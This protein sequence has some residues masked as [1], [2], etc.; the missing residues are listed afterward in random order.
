M[1]KKPQKII[2]VACL[3]F[4]L[5]VVL[6]GLFLLNRNFQPKTEEISSGEQEDFYDS[7]SEDNSEN[8]NFLPEF[9]DN[10]DLNL[11]F[12]GDL[13]LDRNVKTVIGT[14]SP[15]IL[16]ADLQEKGIF[17]GRDLISANLEGAVIQDGEYWPPANIYDFSFSPEFVASLKP[18]GFDFFNLAN[19]HLSD[20]GENGIIETEKNLSDL[21]FAFSGCRDQA[22]GDCT[23]RIIERRGKKIGL[24]GA[25]M[26]YGRFDENEFLQKIAELASTTDLVIAQVHWGTEYEHY[27]AKNQIYLAHQIIDAGADL[28]IGHHPH[29]VSGAEIYENKLIFYSLG[30]FVFDQ[31]FS[32]DT[33][34]ELGVGILIS[35]DSFQASLLPIISRKSHLYLMEEKEKDEFLEKM[36]SW[37]S[38]GEDFKNQIKAGLIEIKK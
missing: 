7:S 1:L 18:L 35:D 20:Q 28:I 29:V 22:A 2:F 34:E 3:V 33:Q 13:M 31:Y 15:E 9:Q 30:N 21:D 24:A 37:S 5:S 26:V 19:N 11:L 17:A 4:L 36:A 38:G 32:Q 16:L 6:A 25:S 27:P 23:A 8:E 10:N 14:S 12:F